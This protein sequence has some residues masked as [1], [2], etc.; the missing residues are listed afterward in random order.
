MIDLGT[1]DAGPYPTATSGLAINNAGQ[2]TG[3]WVV[4]YQRVRTVFLAS[5][6]RPMIN[7]GSL[8]SSSY[9][10]AFPTAINDAAQVTGW[11]TAGNDSHAFVVSAGQPMIDLGTLG[12]SVSS[13]HDINAA[14]QV[15]GEAGT[16]D[17]SIHAFVATAGQP[18]IDLGTLPGDTSSSGYAI[19]DAG[20]VAGA[21][22]GM[23]DGAHRRAFLATAI[24]LLLSQLID[25]TAA[26]SGASQLVPVLTSA[27]AA[28]AKKDLPQTCEDLRHYDVAVTE[29]AAGSISEADAGSLLRQS[30]AITDALSCRLGEAG[31]I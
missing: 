9:P 11:S 16:G 30:A 25:A 2:V 26:N 14:G 5:A 31:A 20:Q 3:C 10:Y 7:L 23:H 28:Y 27:E 17:W 4:P 6:D 1:L 13:G 24:N 12:G 15:T 21:S 18:M 8:P 22:E 19:N 29:L